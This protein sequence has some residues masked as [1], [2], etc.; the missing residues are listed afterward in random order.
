MKLKEV[1][2]G[3]VIDYAPIFKDVEILGLTDYSKQCKPGFIFIA[4]QGNSQD[5]TSFIKEAIERGATV[6]I[7]NISV[8]LIE[9]IKK[10]KDVIFIGVKDT[11]YILAQLAANFYKRPS[12]RIKVI[13]V[14]GTNGKTTTTYLIESILKSMGFKTGLIGTINY[15]FGQ[16][17]IPALNTTPGALQLQELLFHME[18]DGIE[19]VVMEV[20]SH[21][22]QQGRVDAI[23]FKAGIFTNITTDHLD[24]HGDFDNY[25]NAKAKLFEK[26]SQSAWAII[27]MDD[28][29]GKDMLMRT[30][31]KTITYAINNPAD[32]EAYE[33]SLKR[34]GSHFWVGTPY[35]EMEIKTSLL[36][37]HNVYNILAAI[38]LGI[39][40]NFALDKIKEGI[41]KISYVSGRLEPVYVGQPFQVFIDYAHTDDALKNVLSSLK[42]LAKGRIIIVFGCGGDRCKEKRPLMGKVASELADFIILTTDNPRSEEPEAI[43]RD[44]E[45]GFPE[46]FKQYQ[47]ILDRYAAIKEAI[48]IAEENDI[49]LIAGKGHEPYQIFKNITVPFDDRLVAKE[50]LLESISSRCK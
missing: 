2:E 21:G 11:R 37:M 48:F 38:S 10:Y 40:E 25:F 39:T 16:R 13:G 14:T 8:S 7:Y 30:S 47:I 44:I 19:Y 33:I 32:V 26:L 46:G 12:S 28:T 1:L 43:I 3:L 50:L 9:F 34:E 42:T 24:Y 5:G 6:V 45:S 35:G 17:I 29:K 49:V 23:D 22:L 27:N 36:G 18:H 20:S 15:R 4:V 41:E 31:A